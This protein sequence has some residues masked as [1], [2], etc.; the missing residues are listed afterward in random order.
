MPLL[1]DPREEM[2][3]DRREIKAAFSARVAF[4]NSFFGH[5]LGH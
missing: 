5:M 4:L 3:G 1:F 2:I